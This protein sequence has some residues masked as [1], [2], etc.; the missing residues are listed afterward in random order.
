MAAYCPRTYPPPRDEWRESQSCSCC[1]RR[2]RLGRRDIAHLVH[3]EERIVRLP[4]PAH[5]R[6]LIARGEAIDLALAFFHKGAAQLGAQRERPERND[7]MR[8]PSRHRNG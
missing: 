6:H 8:P 2:N 5:F 7:R 3:I 4:R 1:A